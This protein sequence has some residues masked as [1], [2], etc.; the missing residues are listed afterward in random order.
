MIRLSRLALRAT[1]GRTFGVG[2]LYSRHRRADM[3]GLYQAV[4]RFIDRTGH[5]QPDPH[6]CAKITELLFLSACQNMRQL[7]AQGTPQGS[8]T[9]EVYAGVQSL[10]VML[11]HTIPGISANLL[12]NLEAF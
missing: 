7:R 9:A 3:E 5:R 11:E 8:L 4:R 1:S 10:A 2:S 12:S 6:E